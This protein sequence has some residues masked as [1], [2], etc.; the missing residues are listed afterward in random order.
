MFDELDTDAIST[1]FS[2]STL[3]T[4]PRE[5]IDVNE[6]AA[7]TQLIMKELCKLAKL[8]F[9]LTFDKKIL[10]KSVFVSTIIGS[11]DLSYH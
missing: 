10:Y 7:P 5:L 4:S 9:R 11:F 8:S 2:E 6:G 3:L 1:V